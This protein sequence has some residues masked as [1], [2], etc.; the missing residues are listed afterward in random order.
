MMRGDA[1]ITTAFAYEDNII[2]G[3]ILGDIKF[4]SL[5]DKKLTRTL[6]CPLKKRSQVNAIDLCDDGDYIFS[7]FGNGNITTFELVTN[8]CKLVNN[9]IHKTGC[10]NLKFIERFDK[11]FFRIFSSDE[12][13]NVFEIIIKDGLFGFSASSVKLFCGNRQCPTF[14]IYLLKFKDNEIKNKSYLKKLNKSLILGNLKKTI[15]TI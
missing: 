7:G 9:T 11:K 2:T 3:D 15:Y 12:E 14:L 5:K 1:D 4:Y 10:I 13:G 8:K 6:P